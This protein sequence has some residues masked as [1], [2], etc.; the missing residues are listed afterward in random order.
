MGSTFVRAQIQLAISG[1][2][3]LANNLPSSEIKE[4]ILPIPPIENQ[5][6]I[7]TAFG[8]QFDRFDAIVDHG[9]NTLRLLHERR[10]A[11]IAAAVT[12]SLN[13]E[14]INR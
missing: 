14:G 3:G 6:S 4:F 10:T 11:L 7:V 5:I 1:A 12:G 2:A 9:R 8:K 13:I